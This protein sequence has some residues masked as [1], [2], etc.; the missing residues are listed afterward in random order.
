VLGQVVP[1]SDFEVI[2]VNDSG[3]P[4]PPADWQSAEQ[5]RWLST[6]RRERGVARNA[7]AAI[8]RGRYLLFLDDD[9][10]L[11]PDA[12]QHFWAM[13]GEAPE[14]AW[15]FGKLRVVD[16]AGQVLVELD[17][18][19]RGNCL[20]QIMAGVYV[21]SQ[22]SLI[23]SRAFFDVG[24][25]NP[26]ICGTEDLDLCRRI[27]L[28]G[29]FA[30]T[31]AAVACMLRGQTWHT[32]TDYARAPEDNRRSR[33][34][35][36]GQPGALRRM[37]ASANSGYW[38][39]RIFRIYLSTIPFHLKQNRFFTAASRAL[40]SLAWLVLAGRYSVSR[41]FWRGVKA[42]HTPDML[43]FMDAVEQGERVH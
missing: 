11:L 31:H 19:L 26:S 25:Y 9:D 36:L 22:A 35:V 27:A 15:L 40:S 12:F 37:A 14:A 42:H 6:N 10:W 2:V 30:G 4:L 41:G 21:P 18:G 7:G 34:D 5:V 3:K 13:A 33:D 20:A 32:S 43:G 16:E 17:S 39:G 24:G 23:Q 1:A 38:Y 28:H 8:A 29:S